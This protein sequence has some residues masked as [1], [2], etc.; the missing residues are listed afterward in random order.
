[1][2]VLHAILIAR[3]P[4]REAGKWVVMK[5]TIAKVDLYI[6][7]YGW[8][9][10]GIAYFVVSTCGTTIRHKVDYCTS[11]NCTLPL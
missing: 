2:K 7:A 5:A 3:Y 9:N 4:K 1:M 10:R 8:S 11:F 6:M